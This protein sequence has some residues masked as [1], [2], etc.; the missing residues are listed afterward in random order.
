MAVFK[1]NKTYWADFS[2]HGQRF[3]QSLRTSAWR[4]AVAAEKKLI[5]QAQMAVQGAA[6]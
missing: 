3:R 2:V 4:E 5:A 1:R 6:R